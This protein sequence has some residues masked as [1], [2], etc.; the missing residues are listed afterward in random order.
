MAS[1]EN[2]S[3]LLGIVDGQLSLAEAKQ[4]LQNN[5]N[6][7]NAAVNTFFENSD[8]AAL[9]SQLRN[10]QVTWDKTAFGSAGYGADDGTLPS[11][12]SYPHSAVNSRAPTRPNSRTSLRTNMSTHAGDAPIHQSIETPQ[13]S[14]V[15]GNS[16]KSFGP[17]TRE[18][19]EADQW[20]MV[21]TATE[22]I[23]DPVPNQRQREREQGQPA[24]LK[25]SPNFNYLPALIPILHS[26]PLF[27]NALL[28]PG[29]SQK[30]YWVGDDWW[31][32]S[33]TSSGH[34]YDVNI[35]LSEAH[36]LAVIHE[37]QRLMAFLD[38]TD[39]IY[40]SINSLLESDAWRESQVLMGDPDDDLL[41]FLLLWSFA[42]QS[43][44][45]D[46]ELNGVL[47][48]TVDTSGSVQESFV[49]DATVT[50]E[51]KRSNVTLYDVLDGTL[52]PE[53]RRAHIIDPSSVLILRLTSSNPSASELGCRIPATLYADRYLA[54]NKHIIDDM[55]LDMEQHEEQLRSMHTQLE[56]LKYHTPKKA[57]ASKVASLQLLSASMTAF[58]PPGD[59]SEQSPRDAATY[60]QLQSLFLSIESKLATLD[61][62]IQQVQKITAG[63]SGRFKPRVDDGADPAADTAMETTENIAEKAAED[64][65]VID[66]P[67]G[68]RPEDAM[69]RPYQL[70]GV[71][72]RRDVVYILQPDINSDVPGAKQWWRMQYDSESHNPIIRRD[73]LSLEEVLER[74]T[75]ESASALFVYANEAATSAEPILLPKPLEDFVKKD[76]LNFLEELQRSTS[77]TSPAWEGFG[78]D[79]SH[80]AQGGWDNNPNSD[81]FDV[82]WHGMNAKPFYSGGNERN[83]SNM[84][85]ATLTPNTEIDDDMPVEM[86]EVGPGTAAMSSASSVTVGRDDAMDVDEDVKV[87]FTDVD[88]DKADT[89]EEVRTQHIEVAEKKGG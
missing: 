65:S 42:F 10:T 14:G 5:G 80:V 43:Q 27:R 53:N 51:N 50:P 70:Y 26:I 22:I 37:A 6:D 11:L 55:C 20:A 67:E 46:A 72:T 73:R 49:V 36:G 79:Y 61:E 58:K 82:D 39:R 2:V 16:N 54:E 21:T 33:A 74:A 28:C 52:F 84:S 19:Y 47:R 4:L 35:G 41:R 87:S 32:G 88:M 69:K 24:I 9:K 7:I 34:P 23:S 62:Q 66:Y 60:S 59:G 44:M 31:R 75:T 8:I 38:N 76:N 29:I 81:A 56:R 18:A 1:D 25:P 63:I 40:G 17:A 77:A 48:S 78:D 57:G 3:S 30:D 13:E 64:T 83:D 86:M 45:P 89:Q 68:Q 12:E 71:A 15:V 85:S